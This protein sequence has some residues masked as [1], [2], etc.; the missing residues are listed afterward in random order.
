M[1][2]QFSNNRKKAGFK[3]G[4]LDIST[5]EPPITS[6]VMK[7][8]PHPKDDVTIK[9]QKLDITDE[10]IRKNTSENR[11]KIINKTIHNI[12]TFDDMTPSTDFKDSITHIKEIYKNTNKGKILTD[13]TLVDFLTNVKPFIDTRIKSGGDSLNTTTHNN[14]LEAYCKTIP[15]I[16]DEDDLDKYINSNNDNIIKQHTDLKNFIDSNKNK[17]TLNVTLKLSSV[18]NFNIKFTKKYDCYEY[19]EGIVT[20]FESPFMSSRYQIQLFIDDQ[21][22]YLSSLTVAQRRLIRDYTKISSFDFY[23]F[24]KSG[25]TDDEIKDYPKFFSDSFYKQI[26]EVTEHHLSAYTYNEWLANDRMAREDEPNSLYDNITVNEW[27][28]ILEKFIK[29]LSDIINN[30]PPVL[31]PIH[32]FRGSTSHYIITSGKLEQR[33]Y[34]NMIPANIDTPEIFISDRISSYTFSFDV[35]NIFR[36]DPIT[37]RYT[38][39]SMIYR[40]CIMPLCRVLLVAPISALPEEFE[41]IS[42]P[43]SIFLYDHS[44]GTE[45]SHNNHKKIYGIC[46]N[47][48]DVNNC[49]TSIT[50]YLIQTPI[51]PEYIELSRISYK[52]INRVGMK[53]SPN[54]TEDDIRIG[55]IIAY[56]LSEEYASSMEKNDKLIELISNDTTRSQ[57]IEFLK[58]PIVANTRHIGYPRVYE[59]FGHYHYYFKHTY[60]T[61]SEFL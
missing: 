55:Q 61:T 28:A 19:N 8:V 22:K 37:T 52:I 7:Q 50:T 53:W 3:G 57:I 24:V 21:N 60:D 58:K 9:Q 43:G 38:D 17:P 44:D 54:D 30:A 27:K 47:E 15:S 36:K 25:A 4:R 23:K 1:K 41:F 51:K 29:D 45:K 39:T 12:T 33:N 13:S 40:A 56:I 31:H 26:S 46:S 32:C 48:T 16:D 14:I 5:T 34:I 49:F 10:I 20:A 18:L 11:N 59:V 2:K 6:S 42:A 35:A